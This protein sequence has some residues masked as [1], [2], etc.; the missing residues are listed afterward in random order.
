MVART[1]T[2]C[3]P[4][5]IAIARDVCLKEGLDFDAL[6]IHQARGLLY[7]WCLTCRRTYPLTDLVIS[8][9]RKVCTHC[10]FSIKMH[11]ASNKF[12]KLRRAILFKRLGSGLSN[13]RIEKN[14]ND[15]S[16]N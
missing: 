15:V 11:G 13:A 2:D 16:D 12:G 7:F 5:L 6:D 3:N 8:K 10:G 4:N 1:L 9:K 14:R